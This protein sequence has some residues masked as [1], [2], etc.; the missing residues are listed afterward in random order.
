MAFRGVNVPV[1]SQRSLEVLTLFSKKWHPVVVVVLLHHDRM[2]FNDLLNSIPA[3]SG[4]LLSTTLDALQDAGL[5]E[6]EIVSE[7]PLRV[8]YALTESG[9]ELAP[10]FEA[11]AAWGERH[12]ESSTATEVLADGDRRITEMYQRW[13]RDR[14][15]VRRAHNGDELEDRLDEA[16]DVVLL[17]EELPAT[18]PGCLAE[19]GG[20]RTILLVGDRPGVD[21]L[22]IPCDDV[23]RKPVVRETVLEAIDQQL[24]WGNDSPEE[25]ERTALDA[26]LSMLES[27]Y[28]SG[29]LEADEEYVEHR[30]RLLAL[31]E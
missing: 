26:K 23:L 4:K 12:L 21:L 31:E 29:V 28:P 6:R 10:I 24:A 16:V 18:E 14:H 13:L 22:T 19:V 1:T 3:V 5:V 25:R 30:S 2:G 17:D 8:K 9:R 11:L 7:S 27:V 20:C 15:T